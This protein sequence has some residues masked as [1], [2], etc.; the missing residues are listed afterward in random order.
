MKNRL[1]YIIAGAFFAFVL[2]AYSQN[3]EI[4][5]LSGTDAARTVDWEFFCTEGRKSGQWTTIP[6][7][8]N[9]EMQGFG[10]YSYGLE[11]YGEREKLGKEKGLYRYQF[12]VPRDWK[13]RVVKLVFDG[14]MIDTRVWINGKSA[15]PVHQGG[16]YR[17]KYDTGRLLKYGRQNLLEVEVAKVSANE[18]VNRAEKCGDYWSFGG[19]Y[20]PVFLEI[21]PAIHMERVAL[22]PRADGSFRAHVEFSEKL[23]GCSIEIDLK[24]M[25]GNRI[26]EPGVFE[27]VN[28]MDVLEVSGRYE[29]ITAWSHEHPVLYDMSFRLVSENKVLHELKQ[30]IG[31]RTIELRKHDGFYLNGEKVIFKGVDR[32]SF[33]PETGRCLSEENLRTDIRLIREMNMNAVRCS[34]YPPDK[35]FLELCDSLGLLVLDEVAGWQDGYDTIVGPG[36]IRETVLRDEN[37][38]SVVIWDHGNEGG[39]NFASEVVFHE[40]DIQD[41]PVIYPWL[42]R[43][44]LDTHH[45]PVF[46]HAVGRSVNGN[47][48]FMATELLHGLYAVSY[49]HLRAHET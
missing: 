3:T 32:H 43:N 28:G 33:W 5:Y 2:Q 11:W 16:F 36:L 23:S 9:W 21:L 45:Y 12:V 25:N 8:S 38:P 20:R 10:S 24:D 7:P 47:D 14:S 34:H 13:D 27:C 39:W 44:G 15:G 46:D 19:I 31:F 6:V 18:S 17:F 30:R 42:L 41:R 4:V 29:S 22:D 40:L 26:G 49:T 1:K 35:R 37:H 48:P